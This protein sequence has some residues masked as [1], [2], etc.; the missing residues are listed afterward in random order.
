MAPTSLRVKAKVL[1]V[2]QKA[3]HDLSLSSPHLHV[4]PLSLS[5]TLFSP[6]GLLPAPLTGQA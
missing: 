5:L 2:A 3:L 6:H 1:R 4:L